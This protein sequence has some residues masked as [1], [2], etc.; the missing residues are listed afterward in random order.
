MKS[1]RKKSKQ[2]SDGSK[3]KLTNNKS[4]TKTK[5]A[6]SKVEKKQ[7]NPFILKDFQRNTVSYLK[8]KD[9]R[10]ILLAFQTGTGK[11]I[12]SLHI[13]KHFLNYPIIIFVP[14]VLIDY[15]Q[16][17][18]I[19]IFTDF[20]QRQISI[21]SHDSLKKSI[22]KK[23]SK[24]FDNSVMIIDEIHNLLDFFE[25]NQYKNYFNAIE[26][27]HNVK[28]T[29]LLSATP[30]KGDI[31]KMGILINLINSQTTIPIDSFSFNEKYR[32]LS[33]QASI[34]QILLHASKNL[35]TTT[36]ILYAI[37]T[38]S[39]LTQGFAQET[40]NTYMKINERNKCRRTVSGAV[41]STGIVSAFITMFLLYLDK[42][43]N[44]NYN[45]RDRF[46][47]LPFKQKQLQQ[48][49]LPYVAYFNT[50]DIDDYH[51]ILPSYE[52]KMKQ[53]SYTLFQNQIL[54][55]FI[56][57]KY[58]KKFLRAIFETFNDD[59]LLDIKKGSVIE[60]EDFL[61]IGGAVGNL[62]PDVYKL[63]EH[64]INIHDETYRSRINNEL[65]F[66]CDK[67]VYLKNKIK[68]L[69][70]NNQKCVI[71]S[72]YHT[73]GALIFSCYLTKVGITHSVLEYNQLNTKHILNDFNQ[74]E[75]DKIHCPVL[76][77]ERGAHEGINLIGV[78]DMFILE[79]V[80]D[81]DVMEQVIGRP[82]RL[83]SHVHLPIKKRHVNFEIQA[84]DNQLK[85]T[86][87]NSAK[88]ILS[89]TPGIKEAMLFKDY[90]KLKVN[91]PFLLSKLSYKEILN[92]GQGPDLTNYYEYILSQ[93][94]H[95]ELY[96]YIKER[97]IVAVEEKC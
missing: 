19:E 93:K 32:D 58:D 46:R 71:Y 17:T 73:A 62:S 1:L 30:D 65:D 18:V 25:E 27:F 75:F 60:L 97:G 5:S 21:F 26:T 6:S 64:P 88:N 92:G 47:G 16:M 3:K 42:F 9:I 94:T 41:T 37:I 90:Q 8:C 20:E 63:K 55:D 72:N 87:I 81:L 80:S 77:L 70:E 2:I 39:G 51:K 4:T 49:I 23:E 12:T 31:G 67:F 83:N 43:F 56:L 11:T 85:P 89:K 53:H 66:T 10:G 36:T 50:T 45:P 22:A 14:T 57:A 38:L 28:K 84:C 96:K 35:I 78:C 48:D 79:P 74:I 82:I 86:D 29:I 34:F 7:K 95:H 13:V 69:I 54:I 52:V 44:V 61:K 33:K 76:I 59:D 40:C 91:V 24:K 68:G 15:W